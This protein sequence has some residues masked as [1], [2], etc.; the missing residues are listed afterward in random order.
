MQFAGGACVLEI[1]AGPGFFSPAIAA[2]VPD[3]LLVL[4]DL[5]IEMVRLARHRLEGRS[6]AHVV[7][8][9]ATSLPF[10]TSSGDIT[11]TCG[12]AT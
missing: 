10:R 8:A 3:G 5:Q 1:G 6:N 4:V 7:V 2:A 9:D 12:S 11:R